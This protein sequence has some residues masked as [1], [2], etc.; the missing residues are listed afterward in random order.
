MT[1]SNWRKMITLYTQKHFTFQKDILPALSGITNRVRGAGHYYG[2][3]WEYTLPYDL[4]WFSIAGLAGSPSILPIRPAEYIAPSFLWSSIAGSISFVN[5]N[6]DIPYKQS[7]SIE[8]ISC[9]PEHHDTLGELVDG[10]IVLR[11]RC[12]PA[13]F[14]N[15]FEKPMPADVFI[16]DCQQGL[17][18]LWA[19]LE[20]PG[21]GHYIFHP[22]TLDLEMESLVCME[23][24]TP[25]D[26]ENLS[27]Y[28][29]VLAVDGQDVSGDSGTDFIQAKRVGIVA[30]IERDHFAYRKMEL[31]TA[32]V[33]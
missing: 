13:R 22:D 29:L 27:C 2:G 30:S 11:G 21:I 3:A 33:K 25:E 8:G 23:L 20:C 6:P 31:T 28:A 24:F 18:C 14:V 4:L 10:N 9:I 17:Y 26:G 16:K 32:V 5:F 1:N 7:F 15:R 12:I 19:T